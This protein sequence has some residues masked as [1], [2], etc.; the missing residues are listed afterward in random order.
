MKLSDFKT[1]AV[2]GL[3]SYDH[4]E[5]ENGAFIQRRHCGTEFVFQDAN[6]SRKEFYTFETLK[7]A[8]EA[9]E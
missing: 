4:F 3:Y 9:S 7:R 1:K 8:V 6:G 2:Q 5:A